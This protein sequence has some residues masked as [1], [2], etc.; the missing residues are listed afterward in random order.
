MTPANPQA[1][2][3]ADVSSE[4]LQVT[5]AGNGVV[6]LTLNRPAV[7]NSI[8][9]SMWEPLRQIFQEI[10]E[11]ESDRVLVITGDGRKSRAADTTPLE[12]G[13]AMDI[14]ARTLGPRGATATTTARRPRDQAGGRRP[15]PNPGRSRRFPGQSGGP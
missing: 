9:S 12:A 10:R 8:T 15:A 2:P 6:T 4:A 5:R 11:T 14:V 7:K 1:S 13:A 3:A